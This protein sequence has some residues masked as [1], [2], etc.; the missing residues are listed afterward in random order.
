MYINSN[1]YSDFAT[2]HSIIM[3]LIEAGAHMDTV[4]SNGETPYDVASTG[5]I[6]ALNTINF[7]CYTLSLFV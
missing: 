1:I 3:E 4:N 2:F 7:T 6:F 5:M